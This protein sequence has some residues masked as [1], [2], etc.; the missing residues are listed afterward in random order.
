MAKLT[1][2]TPR[3]DF[4]DVLI[5]PR[6]S[7]VESRRLVNLRTK[8]KFRNSG[9]EWQGVPIISSNMDT[10]TDLKTHSILSKRGYLT[11]FPKHFNYIWATNKL[12]IALKDTDSYALSCGINDRDIDSVK[13]IMKKLADQ[14][15]PLRF[16]CVD[17]ANGYLIKLLNVCSNFREQHPNLTI[18]AGNVVTSA[19]VED[20]I[21]DGG[22]DIV[23]VGI[24]S[25]Q[26]CL[27]RRM[28]GVGYPQLSAVMECSQAATS[29]GAHIISDGGITC[30]GDVAKAFCAGAKFVMLGS[31]LAGHDESPGDLQPDGTKLFYGMSSTL[32]NNKHAGGMSNYKAS[33]GRITRIKCKGPIAKT[34]QDIEGGLRSCCAYINAK[35]ITDMPSNGRFVMVNQQLDM[36]L[37]KNTVDT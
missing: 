5:V 6:S 11:C 32:A 28:T 20:L 31:M 29:L 17:I 13:T 33:E 21:L 34:L 23:K 2:T 1:S 19:A 10:V 35:N 15:T 3:L 24:G 37:E 36:S 27:T 22:V 18:I 14:E 7:F 30:P 25:G 26:A 8:T 9:Q 16:L 12:P 4:R